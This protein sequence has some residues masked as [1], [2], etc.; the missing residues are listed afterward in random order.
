MTYHP[1]R[2]QHMIH[3]ADGRT[4][5][6]YE[7]YQQALDALPDDY[8]VGHPG[9]LSDWGDRTLFWARAEDAENDDGQR[10]AGEIRVA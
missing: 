10:A 7:S 8:E 1:N 3:W 5:G 9:D 2:S 6:P 4:D